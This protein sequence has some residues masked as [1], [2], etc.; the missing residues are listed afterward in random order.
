MDDKGHIW[1]PEHVAAMTKLERKTRQLVPI[2]NAE[3]ERLTAANREARIA[4]HAERRAAR[5]RKAAKP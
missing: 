5:L 4:W 1:T 3:L 2:P